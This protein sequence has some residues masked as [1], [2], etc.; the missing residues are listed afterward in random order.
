[1]K[2]SRVEEILG[3]NRAWE[4]ASMDRDKDGVSNML[5]CSPSNPRKQG[6]I[7]DLG[8]RFKVAKEE[9]KADKASRI[10]TRSESRQIRREERAKYTKQEAKD[11]EKGRYEKRK[12]QNKTGG[13]LSVLGSQIEKSTRPAQSYKKKQYRRTPKRK[14]KAAQR[15]R[16]RPSRPS[17]QKED[18]D[19][20]KIKSFV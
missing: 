9:R 18:Y 1:M 13:F 11:K 4:R 7:H 14:K 17:Y 8:E 3:R 15:V 10:E 6:I 2:N 19:M 20:S 16:I 5:D 12:E